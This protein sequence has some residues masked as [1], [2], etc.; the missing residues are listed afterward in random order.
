MKITENYLKKIIKEERKKLLNEVGLTPQE[1]AEIEKRSA[2]A[3]AAAQADND[4]RE[5][6]KITLIIAKQNLQPKNLYI[7]LSLSIS[8]IF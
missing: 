3:E 7:S 2:D 4:A 8:I 1:R 5:F 6:F